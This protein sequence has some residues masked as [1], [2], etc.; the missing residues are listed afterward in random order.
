MT[1]HLLASDY[2]PFFECFAPTSQ[3]EASNHLL[4][5]KHSS[6]SVTLTDTEHAIKLAGGFGLYQWYYLLAVQLLTVIITANYSFTQYSTMQAK[7]VKK[8]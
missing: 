2:Q 8:R 1:T 5:S 7:S 4:S 6:V 3:K